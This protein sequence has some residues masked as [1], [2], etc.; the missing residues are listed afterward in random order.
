MSKAQSVHLRTTISL[1]PWVVGAFLLGVAVCILMPP[2]LLVLIAA[3]S[4]WGLARWGQQTESSR[5]AIAV[6]LGLGTAAGLFLV[7][8]IVRNIL[9]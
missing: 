3:L 5:K 4:A 2:L 9:R 6:D 7:I 8:L 1:W